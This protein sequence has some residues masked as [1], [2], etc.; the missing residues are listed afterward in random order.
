MST[1]FAAGP[2][3]LGYLYQIQY[4]LLTLLKAD[5]DEANSIVI[6]GLDDV[7]L[8]GASFFELQQLKHH[9]GT[10]RQAT[11]SNTS[12]DLWKSIRVWSEGLKEKRWDPL[13]TKLTLIT[14]AKAVKGSIAYKL[15]DSLT[16][17][18][19]DEA[20]KDLLDVANTSKSQELQ[21]LF[22]IFKALK[23]G[24]KKQL[25]EAMRWSS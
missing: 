10:K 7:E 1:P 11:L 24:Q 12:A 23:P 2:Q 25:V 19:T 22:D 3:A 16:E 8:N 4:A 20:L 18:K 17:R 15:R 13:Q 14:T 21:E 6:E 5:D 9:I